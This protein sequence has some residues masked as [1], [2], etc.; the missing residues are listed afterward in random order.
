[1]KLLAP[2]CRLWKVCRYYDRL[3]YVCST[4]RVEDLVYCGLFERML[5]IRPYRMKLKPKRKHGLDGLKKPERLEKPCM[6]KPS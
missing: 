6:T 1:V 4:N 5:E 2:R 3:S